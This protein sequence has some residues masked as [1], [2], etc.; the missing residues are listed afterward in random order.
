[1]PRKL[2]TFSDHAALDRQVGEICRTAV[3]SRFVFTVVS[4]GSGIEF[5]IKHGLDRVPSGYVLAGGSEAII[6]LWDG[7]TPSDKETLYLQVSA[8]PGAV[9]KVLV[10]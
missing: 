7:T 3:D 6:S 9:F 5:S 10:F 8:G 2:V 1:M 4:P